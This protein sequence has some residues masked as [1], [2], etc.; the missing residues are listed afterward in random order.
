MGAMLLAILA[1]LVPFVASAAPS[2][3]VAA[4]DDVFDSPSA[5]VD[6]SGRITWTN[7]GHSPHDVV[8]DDG[9]FLSP[10]MK[11]G[12]TY[13]QVFPKQ[14]AFKYFCSFHGAAGG[15]GMSGAIYVGEKP[16]DFASNSQTR[17]YPNRPPPRPPLGRV[18]HVPVDAPTIQAGVDAAH[19]GDMVL[20]A[21]GVYHEAVRVTTAGITIRGED[22]TKVILDGDLKKANKNGIAVFAA[23]GVAIENMTARH[24]QL[25][26][27][28]WR[29]VY[30]FRG[31]YLT[32]YN[33][34]DYGLYA[35]D[36]G[37]GMFDHDYASGH[38]D[39]GFYIGQCHPCNAL[40]TNVVATGN[41]LGYSGTNAGGNMIIRDSDWFEN[42]AGIVPNT[43]DSEALPPQRG[44]VIVGN[45]VHGN[46]NRSAPANSSTFAAFG[47]G[48]VLAGGSDNEVAYNLVDDHPYAGIAVAPNVDK[49]VW[50]ASDNRIHDNAVGGSGVAD[51]ALAGPAARGN[52]FTGNRFRSSIPPAIEET[53]G[54]ESPIA[55]IGGGDLGLT[56]FAAG[57]VLRSTG[58]FPSGDWRSRP[59]PPTLPGMPDV[60]VAPATPGLYSPL[61][62]A[63]E[64]VGDRAGAVA[65]S[66]GPG[67]P[68]MGAF[69]GARSPRGSGLL[70]NLFFGVLGYGLPLLFIVAVASRLLRRR[71]PE[72]PHGLARTRTL[73]ALPVAYIALVLVAVALGY[74]GVGS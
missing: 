61:D 71:L 44:V 45:W 25:N 40:I 52:C 13:S 9:S 41:A 38:P 60:T 26:G 46:H 68:V 17:T 67:A 39:S 43:L 23:D 18:I 57:Y 53:Y 62:T 47:N 30:G 32:A 59:A 14:G 42:R 3:H 54:C 22:R 58:D 72:P 5:Q 29:S 73:V 7:R 27:F 15:K 4:R 36:S 48:I 11:P 50:V 19:P 63:A 66:I 70:G 69:P 33:N 10:T 16:Q 21:R 6:I 8:A 2:V 37:F 24:Y 65:G 56:A 12:Q 35:F 34:G 51:L 49:Q 28:Y 64:V 55:S 74:A 31:S 1:P 20:V